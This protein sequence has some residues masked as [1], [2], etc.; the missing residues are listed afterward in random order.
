MNPADKYFISATSFST[1]QSE[2]TQQKSKRIRQKGYEPRHHY[3]AIIGY[4]EVGTVMI[5]GQDNVFS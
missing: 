4:F 2:G 3:C 5:S 1:K